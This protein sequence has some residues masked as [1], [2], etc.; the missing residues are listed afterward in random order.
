MLRVLA[1]DIHPPPALD[2]L[3]LFASDFHGCS[4]LHDRLLPFSI[5]DCHPPLSVSVGDPPAR[6]I[7]GREF[8]LHPV[9]GQNPDEVDPHLPGDVR[10]HPVA[11]GQLDPEH[12]IGQHLHNRPFN[13]DRVLLRHPSPLGGCGGSPSLRSPGS[14]Q[15]PPRSPSRAPRS[16]RSAAPRAAIARCLG[17]RSLGPP[18]AP[19]PPRTAGRLPRRLP[20][21]C[22]AG[23]RRSRGTTPPESPPPAGAG[24]APTRPPAPGRPHPRGTPPPRR[25][26]RGPPE[27]PPAAACR[28]GRHRP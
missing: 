9:I 12:R 28:A 24:G 16:W 15:P 13:L 26:R 11:A 7:I 2:D 10:Q 20:A 6:R 19:P 3:A 18:R 4:N 22:P 25:P 17:R 21:A 5:S 23:P 27:P 14:C 1:D 8:H